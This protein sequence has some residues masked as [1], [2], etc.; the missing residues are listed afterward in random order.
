MTPS[1]TYGILLTSIERKSFIDWVDN[2][3]IRL[4]DLTHKEGRNLVK[5]WIDLFSKK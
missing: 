2:S 4:R 5:F 3:C 1:K